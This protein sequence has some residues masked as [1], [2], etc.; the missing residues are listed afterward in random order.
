MFSYSSFKDWDELEKE[1]MKA[2]A[3][4]AEEDMED[5]SRGHPNHQSKSGHSSSSKKRHRDKDRHRDRSPAK[6]KRRK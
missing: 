5:A 6:K 2:D 3:L 4:K 1:A